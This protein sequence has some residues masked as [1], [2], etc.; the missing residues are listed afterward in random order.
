MSVAVS[1]ASSHPETAVTCGNGTTEGAYNITPGGGS[2][3]APACPSWCSHDPRFPGEHTSVEVPLTFPRV[4]GLNIPSHPLMTVSLYNSDEFPAT[5][6]SI[7]VRDEDGVVDGT[8]LSGVASEAWA[9]QL[10]AFADHVRR[11]ARMAAA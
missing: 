9:D 5:R 7:D 10:V 1:P 11:L 2:G 6:V 3:V 8:C 4:P